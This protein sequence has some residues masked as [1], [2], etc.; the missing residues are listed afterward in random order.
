MKELA[1]V[2]AIA[3]RQVRVLLTDELPEGTVGQ[4]DPEEYTITIDASLNPVER[5]STMLHECIHIADD[6][7][8]L[9]LSHQRVL[10]LELGL[11]QLLPALADLWK[12][13]ADG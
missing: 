13:T 4:W 8:N 3:G 1:T 12:D 9:R 11:M 5:S 7:Y 2:L 10:L 6:L